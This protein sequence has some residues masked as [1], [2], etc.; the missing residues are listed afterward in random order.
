MR[1]FAAPGPGFVRPLCS[2]TELQ[3]A[4][5]CELGCLNTD[6]FVG[7]PR[8]TWRSPMSYNLLTG[9]Q[10]LNLRNSR[11]PCSVW[12]CKLMA[13][14]FPSQWSLQPSRAPAPRLSRAHRWPLLPFQVSV[15]SEFYRRVSGK[16]TGENGRVDGSGEGGSRS[17]S[18]RLSLLSSREH[19]GKYI[20]E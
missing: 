1:G 16:K 17:P 2:P 3:A 8:A 4:G 7:S 15:S 6:L 12:Q 18:S 11:G 13:P 20:D 19:G 9:C 14:L 10:P 5:V